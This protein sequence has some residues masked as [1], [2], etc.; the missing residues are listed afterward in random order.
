MCVFLPPD[1]KHG[2]QDARFILKDQEKE[3]GIGDLG[4]LFIL[5]KKRRVI[6]FIG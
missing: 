6:G 2:N 4:V 5:L 1:T 3:L